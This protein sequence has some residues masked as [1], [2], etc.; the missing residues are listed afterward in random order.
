V[1]AGGTVTGAVG[2]ILQSTVGQPA[3]G[4]NGNADYIMCHGYWCYGGAR[5]VAI[6]PPPGMERELPATLEFGPPYP[7]PAP[8]AVAFDLALPKEAR[9]ELAV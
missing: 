7:N 3:V 4:V 2:I 1:G 9:V 8:G 6:D 5:V